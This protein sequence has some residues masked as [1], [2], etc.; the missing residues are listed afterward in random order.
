[1]WQR[2]D[3]RLPYC[4]IATGQQFGY[5]VFRVSGEKDERA[6]VDTVG[7]SGA[8]VDKADGAGRRAI[9]RQTGHRQRLE[10]AGE[11]NRSH[12]PSPVVTRQDPTPCHESITTEFV[13]YC[14]R[15]FTLKSVV[16]IEGF[17]P[18]TN[19]ASS[20]GYQGKGC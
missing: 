16:I 13:E 2:L 4:R 17:S 20:A 14:K 3:P 18:A 19:S 7:L 8:P 15:I 6:A 9:C 1:L 5:R 11:C 10:G 12:L